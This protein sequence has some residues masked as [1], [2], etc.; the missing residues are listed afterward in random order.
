MADE[1]G[2]DG[3]EVVGRSDGHEHA[4]GGDVFKLRRG[5]LFECTT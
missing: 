4:F 2:R 3:P 1:R 5:E